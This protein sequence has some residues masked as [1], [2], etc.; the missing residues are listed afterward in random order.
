VA[1]SLRQL[2]FVLVACWAIGLFGAR[3]SARVICPWYGGGTLNSNDWEGST[4]CWGS[5]FTCYEAYTEDCPTEDCSGAQ[6]CDDHDF[7]CWTL[8]ELDGGLI[9]TTEVCDSYGPCTFQCG[10]GTF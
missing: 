3:T 9:P 5:W 4:D 7:D 8:C 2:A 1:R 6:Y 10:C